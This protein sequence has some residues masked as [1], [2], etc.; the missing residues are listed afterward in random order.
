MVR[1]AWQFSDMLTLSQSRAADCAQT[2]A[3]PHL[4]KIVI[5][6]LSKLVIHTE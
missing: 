1:Q 2:L 5:T 3:L 4:K 6:P